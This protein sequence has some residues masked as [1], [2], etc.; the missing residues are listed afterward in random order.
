MILTKLFKH[1]RG[2]GQLTIRCVDYFAAVE[3]KSE[4]DDLVEKLKNRHD[5]GENCEC[6]NRGEIR[7]DNNRDKYFSNLLF[8]WNT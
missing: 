2:L 8:L 7:E 3:T 5:I 6:E 4:P 1:H